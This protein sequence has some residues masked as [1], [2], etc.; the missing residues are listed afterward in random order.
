MKLAILTVAILAVGLWVLIRA[1]QTAPIRDGTSA[2]PSGGIIYPAIVARLPSL[3]WTGLDTWLLDHSPKIL[4][5]LW[6]PTG[7]C[8][9]LSGG[10]SVGPVTTVV[11]GLILALTVFFVPVILRRL[12]H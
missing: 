12:R 6:Q 3:P 9:S 5:P 7:P 11:S 4:E 10:Q 8:L 1:P 2:Y